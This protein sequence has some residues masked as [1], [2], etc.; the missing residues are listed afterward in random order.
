SAMGIGDEWNDTFLDQLASRT[1]G[2]SQYISTPRDVVRFLNDRVRALGR[3]LA[4]R[5]TISLAPDPDVKIESAFRLTPTP[6]PVSVETDP[7]PLGQLQMGSNTSIIF[8]LQVP[9][10][11][12]VGF[13]SLLRIDVTAD[14][15]REQRQDYKLITDS[16]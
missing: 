8:Q 13:R 2:T 11:Q 4:E 14:I 9:A 3:A 7:I 5:V 1:G 16:S 15:L 10:L 12:K 6:Q